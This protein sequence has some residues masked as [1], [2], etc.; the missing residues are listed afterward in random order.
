MASYDL[1]TA[2]GAIEIDFNGNGLDQANRGLHGVGQRAHSAGQIMD[3]TANGMAAGGGLIAGGLALAVKSAA[4]FE[5]GL[6]NIK[7]VSGATTAEMEKIRAKALQL[8]KDTKF[9]AT[10]GAQAIEELS[11]AGISTAD[12][13]NGAADA[14]VNLAAAGSIDLPQAAEL[15]ANAMN[16]FGVTAKELPTVVDNIAGAANASAIDVGEL[17]QSLKQVGAVAHLAGINFKDTTVAIALMGQAG[18]KGSDAGTSLKTMLQNLQ[19]QTKAQTAE[20]KRLGLITK[21]G[22]NQFFDAKGNAKGLADISQVLQTALHGMTKQQKLATLGMLFGSDAI[23]GAAILADS[24][25]KGFNKMAGAMDKV[26]AADVAKTKMDNLNGSMEQLKGSLET[27]GIQ[28]GAVLLPSIKKVVDAVGVLTNKFLSLS[29]STQ[30]NITNIALAVAAFL[31]MGAAIIKTVRFVQ[32]LVAALKVLGAAMRLGAIASFISGMARAA[33]TMAVV[34]ARATASGLATFASSAAS[35]ARSM[36]LLAASGARAGASMALVAARAGAAGVASMASSAASA[37]ASMGALAASAA[38]AGAA[39]AVTAARMVLMNT[40]SLV[41]KVA[42]LAWAA[43][44]MILNVA[45]SLNPIGLIV[46]AIVALVAIFILAWKHSETFRN[47]VI[48]AFNAIKNAVQFAIKFVVDFVRKHWF[49]LLIILGGP[50]GLALALIIKYWSQ[51]KAAFS[52]AI[53]FVVNFVKNHWKLILIAITG[54]LGLA[55]AII[56][57]YWDNIK[58]AF[59]AAV[60]FIKA[61]VN[62]MKNDVLGAIRAIGAIVGIITGIF[63]RFHSSVVSRTRAVVNYIRGIPNTIRNFFSGAGSWL[64]NAGK[65]IIQ[66]LINGIVSVFNRLRNTLSS[67]TNIIPSWKGPPKRDATLL[68]R[69]GELIMG[70]LMQGISNQLPALRQLLDTVTRVDITSAASQE[71]PRLPALAGAGASPTA[72]TPGI[73]YERLA[74]ALVDALRDSGV[75]S[76][77]LDG[78]ILSNTVSHHSGRQTQQRRRTG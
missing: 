73:D 78:R 8:G 24:G 55:I 50:I 29:P 74:R 70:G 53:N 49:L 69:N 76:I 40:L 77:S 11:K 14:A 38:R 62:R 63:S 66:G 6:S 48:G 3:K 20:M 34:A 68:T 61:V 17:G 30:K 33:A 13:L 18:I 46:I 44:Q 65:N 12:I 31:L 19:P 64:Y 60:N 56:I 72:S 67:V 7:A 36:A 35:A 5:Q 21:D 59:S 27:A 23:R 51:I 45:M 75:G 42:T 58:G 32:N 25:A 37:A 22:A 28:I 10:E 57:K 43:A 39:M 26:K 4:N 52:A 41:L 2:R 1:G 15:A 71:I 16:A 9:S 54:P 47:I